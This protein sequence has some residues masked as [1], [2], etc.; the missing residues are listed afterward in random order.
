[1]LLSPIV[2]FIIGVV[3]KPNFEAKEKDTLQDGRMKKCPF[4]AEVIK[5]EALTCRYCGKEVG[6]AAVGA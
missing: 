2:G 1:V 3:L 6:P 5:A 4:C